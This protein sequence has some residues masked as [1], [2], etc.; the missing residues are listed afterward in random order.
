MVTT[1]EPS[2]DKDAKIAGTL[3][4]IGCQE[5][6]NCWSMAQGQIPTT[7]FCHDQANHRVEP[8]IENSSANV[9][10][11]LSEQSIRI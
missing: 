11:M 5:R 10:L 9:L 1:D 3:L 4:T 2:E 7:E 6:A 8:C